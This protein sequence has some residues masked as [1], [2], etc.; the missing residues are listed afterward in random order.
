MRLHNENVIREAV[1]FF[2]ENIVIILPQTAFYTSDDA[3]T[4]EI[5]ITRDIFARH[6]K[7]FVFARENATFELLQ[8][9]FIWTGCSF[10]EKAPDMVLYGKNIQNLADNRVEYDVNVC[11]RNDI[12]QTF[13]AGTDLISSLE[14]NYRINSF[15]TVITGMVPRSK[16][17]LLLENCWN[18]IRIGRVTVTDR[19]HGMLFS[20]INGV[21]SVVLDNKTGKVFGVSEWLK[22]TNMVF[23]ADDLLSVQK[24]I[25]CCMN[26]NQPYNRDLLLPYFNDM[27]A[28]I[29]EQL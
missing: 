6:D 17:R 16:R 3:G 19:L 23:K 24:C 29:R 14:K 13:G 12:E 28:K 27:A 5:E 10:V 18:N 25:E 9:R 4:R 21:P 8:N 22:D 15:S 7:L 26:I 1:S 2:P 11:L 20:I